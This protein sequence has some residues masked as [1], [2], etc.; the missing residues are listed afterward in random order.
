MSG[1]RVE[2]TMMAVVAVELLAVIVLCVLM[3]AKGIL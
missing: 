2:V 1:D 3:I